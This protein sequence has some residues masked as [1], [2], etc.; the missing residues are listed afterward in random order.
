ME[1]QCFGS[2]SSGNSYLIKHN[3]NYI[4]LDAGVNVKKIT[5]QISYPK[6]TGI[7]AVLISHEHL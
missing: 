5:K 4:L 1:I 2:G 3:G 7:N 6:L